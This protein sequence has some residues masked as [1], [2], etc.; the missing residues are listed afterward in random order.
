[1]HFCAVIGASDL[2]IGT[3]SSEDKDG[4]RDTETCEKTVERT[5]PEAR[6]YCPY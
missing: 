2:S 1:M 4:D 6:A 3:L 5:P